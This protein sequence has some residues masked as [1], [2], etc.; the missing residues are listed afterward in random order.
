MSI[1]PKL[2]DRMERLVRDLA[3]SETRGCYAVEARAIVPLL[4][5]PDADFADGIAD[6]VLGGMLYP[7]TIEAV[8]K[9]CRAACLAGIRHGKGQRE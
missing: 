4:P 2:V 3:A 6:E 5:D 9:Y 1:D 7:Q 8:H